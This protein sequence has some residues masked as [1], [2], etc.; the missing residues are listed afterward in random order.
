[1]IVRSH[2]LNSISCMFLII[3]LVLITGCGNGGGNKNT[4]LGSLSL[5]TDTF[6]IGGTVSGLG[7]EASL[8][9]QNNGSDNLNITSN[10]SFIFA[11]KQT[12]FKFYNVSVLTPPT[13]QYCTI[14]Y[15]AG[16]VNGSNVTNVDIICKSIPSVAL[17]NEYR[18]TGELTGFVTMPFMKRT[19][20]NV[21]F[22]ISIYA[23]P[24]EV[25]PTGYIAGAGIG[26]A[27]NSTYATWN[28]TGLGTVVSNNI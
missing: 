10:G 19:L 28:I 23:D 20:T 16:L 2:C 11:T 1:M 27:L 14:T 18:F 5:F 4:N 8:I 13:N 6:S 9:L 22:Q 26:F 17:L 3:V 25:W 15:G 12:D 24:N 7:P 21:P